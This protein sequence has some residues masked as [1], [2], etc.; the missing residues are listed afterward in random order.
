[1]YHA[2]FFTSSPSLFCIE[3]TAF[4]ANMI[5]KFANF[6]MLGKK[7]SQRFTSGTSKGV[8]P[9]RPANKFT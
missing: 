4:F 1:M 5:S 6:I 3:V 8:G 2:E 7:K 9:P